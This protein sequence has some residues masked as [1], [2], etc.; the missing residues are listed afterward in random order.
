MSIRSNILYRT[1]LV[2][3]LLAVMAGA[4]I[5]QTI[6]IQWIEGPAL[7][8]L[9]AELT[10]DHQIIPATRGNIYSADGS[11]LATS[12][13]IYDI[14]VDFGVISKS[15]FEAHVD[16]L[17]QKLAQMFPE[18]NAAHYAKILRKAKVRNERYFALKKNVK[19][20]QAKAIKQWPLF[21]LGRYRGGLIVEEKTTRERPYKHLAERTIGYSRSVK[22]VGLEAGYD[23][24]LAGTN[25]KR[26]MQKA[27]GGFWIPINDEN[28]IEPENG[29][30]II[31]T[32]D[33]NLQ[34]VAEHA[35]Y[36][37]MV[38][39][40]AQSGTVILMEVET[41]HVKA[42]ANL[43]R[44]ENGRYTE[45]YNYAIGES[46]EQGST[47]KLISLMALLEEGKAK[48][49][50]SI[51][52]ENGETRFFDRV[53]KDSEPSPYKKLTLQQTFEKSSNVGISKMVYT[54]FKD[55][56]KAFVKHFNNL[57]LEMPL[58]LEIEGEGKPRIK[59]PGE[60]SWYGTT[61]PWMSIGYE[62]LLTPM[63]IVTVY[64]AIANEGKMVKPLFVTAIAKTGRKLE[65]RQAEVLNKS[66]CSRR[67]LER[68]QSALEGVVENGTATNLKNPNYRVAGKTGTAQI[69]DPLRGYEKYYKSSFVGYFPADAPKYTCLVSINGARNGVYYGSLVAGPVFKE[70]ADKIFSSNLDWQRRDMIAASENPSLPGNSAGYLSEIRSVLD[71]L[72]V[73]SQ[74]LLPTNEKQWVYTATDGQTLA[75][76]GRTVKGGMVPNV[77]GMTLRDAL[78]LLEN[79]G[80]KV[81][82]TGQGKIR[83]QSMPAGTNV[84]K[85]ATI[86][87]E[88]G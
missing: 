80:L 36:R 4:V 73:P 30:D 69:A 28:E 46:A 39:H 72:D 64:N 54:A 26:L 21:R 2:F 51:D 9:A 88:L 75:V 23:K 13:P 60:K 16:S 43:G 50:D 49:T 55:N 31:T 63:Q 65:T 42:I 27:A 84:V 25:G 86:L 83:K 3:L 66:I 22:P 32:I 17:A 67:T 74:T 7:R 5:Y 38:K 47:V 18:Q 78:Y 15:D 79:E 37:A 24:V 6:K 12:I 68:L 59:N 44:A 14:R 71:G 53:M 58:N 40:D 77:Q 33:V 62:C 85:G 56:P 34:D 76:R 82:F 1:G 81:R 52:I 20:Q 70:I 41:G 29:S 8:K 10:T 35:L 61:L 19:Y 87:I 57:G 48:L 11:L 45:N